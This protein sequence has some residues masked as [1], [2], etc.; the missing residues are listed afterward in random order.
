MVSKENLLR[1]HDQIRAKG[2]DGCCMR[3]VM[4]QETLGERVDG[5]LVGGKGWNR[6]FG[7]WNGEY[8]C[9][10]Y[11][12]YWLGMNRREYF[13][14]EVCEIQRRMCRGLVRRDGGVMGIA[15]M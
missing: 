9:F 6:S 5:P 13:S 4:M 1:I 2:Y 15:G 11:G 8:Q 3:M 7:G 12:V 14:E 10:G